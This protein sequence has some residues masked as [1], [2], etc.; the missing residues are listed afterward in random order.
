M[1]LLPAM[2]VLFPDHSAEKPEEHGKEATPATKTV[3]NIEVPALPVSVKRST[4]GEI[5]KVDMEQYV[6]SVVASEM[7]ADFESEALKAQAIAART[8]LVN[9]LQHHEDEEEVVITDTTEHQVYKNDTELQALWGNDYQWKMDKIKE[10]VVA[11]KGEVI[12]YEEEPI[13]PTFFS[14]SNGYTEDA[15]DYWGD[16]LPYLKSVESKWEEDNPHFTEQKIIGVSEVGENLGVA[17]SPDE[18]A[19]IDLERTDTNRV[20]KVTLNDTSFTGKE[21]REKLGLRSNDFS[22]QQ[23]NDHF[24]FTTKG[25]GHGVGMS[26]YGANGMAEEGKSYEEIIQYYYQDVQITPIKEAAPNLVAK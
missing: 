21:L 26:Q 25:Y 6:T 11:T 14:M 1:L 23:K 4:T 9:H 18:Q 8:Y 20:K 24:I 19:A 10:A 3:Q 12:T 13:T 17:L 7:P 5:E 15:K 22:I 2:I 16:D